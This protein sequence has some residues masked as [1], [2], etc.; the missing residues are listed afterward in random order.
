MTAGRNFIVEI[1]SD[2]SATTLAKSAG[3]RP[4]GP[5]GKSRR[6]SIGS[7]VAKE[8]LDEPAKPQRVA[9]KGVV[10]GTAPLRRDRRIPLQPV[11]QMRHRR[12]RCSELV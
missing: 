3:S 11:R 1:S 7:E 8:R 9:A 5:F 4:G 10:I 12:E 6:P 2:D